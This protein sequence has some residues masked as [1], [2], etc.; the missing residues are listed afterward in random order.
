[1]EE[2]RL[3]QLIDQYANVY[4]FATKKIERVLVDK[5]MPISLEQFGILRVLEKEGAITAKRLAA[6]TDVHKSAVTSK[7]ARLE[8]KGFVTRAPGTA[9]RRSI[10]IT[11]TPAGEAALQECKQAMT[12]FIHPFFAELEEEELEVFLRVYKKLNNMLE[13]EEA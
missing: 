12:D 13:K 8:E 5:A 11:L 2:K 9:D 7:T 6:E 4:L 10:F 1:M 3:Q